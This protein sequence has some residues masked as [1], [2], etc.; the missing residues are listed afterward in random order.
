MAVERRGGKIIGI[1][2][3]EDL[4]EEIVGFEIRDETDRAAK[5]Q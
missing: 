4:L 5:R 3:I 2:T 1:V